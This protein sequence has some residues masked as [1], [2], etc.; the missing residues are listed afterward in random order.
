[1]KRIKDHAK[2]LGFKGCKMESFWVYNGEKKLSNTVFFH[3]TD[4]R[5]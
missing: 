2:F 5:V 1:M 3:V 4:S